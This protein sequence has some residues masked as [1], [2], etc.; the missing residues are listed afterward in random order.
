[1]SNAFVKRQVVS[2]I[3][4]MNMLRMKDSLLTGELHSL[5]FIIIDLNLGR[6][7]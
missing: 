5:F 6:E 4:H 7:G 3:L 1:M 2:C